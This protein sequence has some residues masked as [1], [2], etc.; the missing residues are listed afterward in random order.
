MA[1][2]LLK[3]FPRRQSALTS[4][5]VVPQDKR[6]AYPALAGDFAV[7]DELV[8]PDFQNS[9]LAALRH[10]HRYRRQQVLILL[11]SA[12]ASGFGGLQ[13]IFPEQRWP[14]I[15]LAGLTGALVLVSAATREVGALTDYLTER[16]KAER[17]RA[18]Y[19]R[20]LSGTGQYGGEQRRIALRRSVHAI[21][22]G[23]EPQ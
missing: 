23:K 9:D 22:S 20:F 17:L 14:G 21:T 13:A 15:V 19:F 10:Q 18:L 3:S 11:G 1:L 8:V 2:S 5:P 4:N 6:A 7:L 12:I 16:V